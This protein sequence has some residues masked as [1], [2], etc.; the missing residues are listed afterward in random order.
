MSA[1]ALT[2]KRP[3]D[4]VSGS[5]A[6][7]NM[8]GFFHNILRIQ[9]GEERK[10]FLFA[11]LG[12]MLNGGLAIGMNAVDA[13]FLSRAGA[14]MLPL[15][16]LLT[17]VIMLIYIP[18][19][20]YLLSRFG[21]DRVFDLTLGILVA[22][23][24]FLYYLFSGFN[25]EATTSLAVLCGVKLYAN[26][27]LFA[28]YSLYWNFTDGYFDILDA[29][30][31]FALFAGGSAFGA[32]IC[33]GL[34][35]ILIEYIP[36]QNLFL[37]WSATALLTVPLL[38][39]LRKQCSKIEEDFSLDET[40]VNFFTEIRQIPATLRK[41]RFV[42][43]LAIVMFVTLSITL[44]C[45]YQYMNVFS[46]TAKTEIKA[47]LDNQKTDSPSTLSEQDRTRI[48][49]TAS[50]QK[51][52]SLFGKLGALVNAFILIVNLFLFN[53]LIAWL[54]VRNMALILP[55]MYI[56]VFSFFLLNY[57]FGSALAGFFAYQGI[58]IAIEQNNQNFL[59]NAMPAGIRKQMRTF[60]EGIAEPLAVAIAGIFL[61]IYGR[62]AG[63]GSI[64]SFLN[65]IFSEQTAESLKSS[66]GIGKLTETGISLIGLCG[67]VICLLM[68]F[69]LRWEYM[70]AMVVNLK[71]G[72]LDFSKPVMEILRNL[73]SSEMVKLVD[74]THSSSGGEVLQAIRL[75]VGTDRKAALNTLQ[76]FWERASEDEK[77]EAQ[78]ILV[79][80]LR[81]KDMPTTLAIIQ[82]LE[83]KHLEPVPELVEELGCQG[84]ISADIVIPW[85]KSDAPEKRSAASVTLWNSW[86]FDHGLASLQT[87]L[88]MLAGKPEERRMAVRALGLTGQERYAHFLSGYL[89]DSSNIVRQETLAAILK[90][91]TRESARL[92]PNI[93]EA[94]ENGAPEQRSLG[95]RILE[96]IGDSNAILPLL[97]AARSFTPAECRQAELLITNIGLQTVPAIASAFQ[98]LTLHYRGRSIAARALGRL[99]FPQSESLSPHV[100]DAELRRAYEFATYQAVLARN[101]N[102]SPGQNLLLRFYTD[103]QTTIVN[104]VL[105]LL[106]IGGRLPSYEL[107]SASLRSANPKERAD[108]VET[109][110]QGCE[111]SLFKMLVP[112]I[113]H[114]RA[115]RRLRLAE[116]IC[117]SKDL[118]PDSI[119]MKSLDSYIPFECSAAMLCIHESGLTQKTD[120]LRRLLLKNESRLV[121]QNILMFLDKESDPSVLS[122]I[123]KVS[124]FFISDFFSSFNVLEMAESVTSAEEIITTGGQSI[125]RKGDE[126]SQLYLIT[127]GE[128][129]LQCNGSRTTKQKG[130]VFGQDCVLGENTRL[131]NAI[132]RNAT[133]LR[134]ER[135]TIVKAAHIYPRIAVELLSR[136]LKRNANV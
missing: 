15:I 51:L 109:I 116:M 129:E 92:I 131:E 118:S 59:F 81:S 53:R 132:S 9:P 98:Q 39:S 94:V 10:V 105:E 34:V 126:S 119:I 128:V 14:T 50:A 124:L 45:E 65:W 42:R 88:N 21:I 47:Q 96:R 71:R 69:I 57:G 44:V 11:V 19:F 17:P 76:I 104:F 58:M 16:Y 12:A 133:V 48:I 8:A 80:I 35:T 75:L 56:G 125:Y 103:V 62:D 101:P 52:A 43:T 41:S 136:T 127:Q 110:E 114:R 79:D 67:A 113:D 107:L 68:V 32:M 99:A 74:I 36:V 33:G 27:W 26:M 130:E 28:L 72:W 123:E 29:K 20:S 31:L 102:R 55:L 100:I 89:Q 23:G 77:R 30:R 7:Q 38:I 46:D 85:L 4:N 18:I 95:M 13:I 1:S 86:H 108:T 60:I 84:L 49:E 90:L 106:T 40:P 120:I 2:I 111:R 135:Q 37:V 112:L 24:C 91:V 3:N 66:L 25:A 83:K 134:L 117:P 87:I 93:L 64:D 54:G 78:L 6:V 22:G 73:G 70:Q 115:D 97:S 121:R 82:W 63:G 5:T 122:N 61:L